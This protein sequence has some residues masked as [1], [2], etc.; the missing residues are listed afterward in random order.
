MDEISRGLMSLDLLRIQHD[1]ESLAGQW[2]GDESGY[3]EEQA[4]V[5]NDIVATCQRL[6]ELLT[7]FSHL[8]E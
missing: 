5:C 4:K 1:A 3:L 7:E 6:N 8:R 2:N